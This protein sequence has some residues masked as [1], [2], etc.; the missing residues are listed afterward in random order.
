MQANKIADLV[1]EQCNQKGSK[2]VSIKA[3]ENSQK[4]R[5]IDVAAIAAFSNY[6]SS[7][8]I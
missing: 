2:F 5:S 3:S 7:Q 1:K 8:S 4:N 6:F